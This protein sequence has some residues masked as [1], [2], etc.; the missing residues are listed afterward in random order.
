MLAGGIETGWGRGEGK[1]K[2]RQRHSRCVAEP[3]ADKAEVQL[4][5]VDFKLRASDSA[6]ELQRE[7]VGAALD[8]PAKNLIKRTKDI[9]EQ[10]DSDG[11]AL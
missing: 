7:I 2:Q 1:A 3:K 8:V 11:L 10:L 5:R 9:A 4:G 6:A